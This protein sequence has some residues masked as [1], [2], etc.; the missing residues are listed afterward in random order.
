MA[1][2][3]IQ[4]KRTSVSGRAAN[5][6][7]LPN[8]GELALNM[9]DGIL[10]S[11]NG[12]VVFEIGA[13]TTNSK[14]SGNLTVKGIIANGSIGTAGYV[15]SSNGSSTYWSSAVGYSGSSGFVGSIGYTGSAGEPYNFNIQ[16]NI[17]TGNGSNTQFTLYSGNTTQNS[18]IVVINGVVQQPDVAYTIVGS[19]NIITFAGTP[20]NNAL[21]EVKNLTGGLYGAVGYQGSAGAPG[22]SQGY[23]GSQ[24]SIGLTGYTGSAG[25]G[26]GGGASVA[27]SANTPGSSNTGDLWWNTE[28]GVLSI[29]Y[30]DGD[31][32]QWV[33]AVPTPA[34][35][36]GYTGS[37]G[38]T[39]SQGDPAALNTASSY[40]FTNLLNFQYYSE[41]VYDFGTVTSNIQLDIT[42][43][44]VQQVTLGAT[45]IGITFSSSGLNSGR[46]SS[47]NLMV[48]QPPGG[49]ALISWPTIKWSGGAAPVLS[50][51]GNSIDMFV[52][53]TL[54]GGTTWFGTASG[55][56]FA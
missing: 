30:N 3:L 39:G 10:Y 13:N 46:S 31:T 56:G 27:I 52:F 54:D 20:S 51:A 48:I 44:T 9:T 50:T 6:T 34:G 8:P 4:I 23:T 49:N 55:K 12:S 2:N 25:T 15:L 5:T 22:G 26:G 11:G 43:G 40:T 36:R 35:E 45:P 1:D 28:N 21:I 14:V 24:G 17:F 16:S 47:I 32:S 29:Y 33:S 19:N 42:N 53:F 37:F 18:V 7:T 41:K 38:F